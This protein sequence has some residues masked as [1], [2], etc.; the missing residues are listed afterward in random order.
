MANMS[1]HRKRWLSVEQAG[2]R[3]C[4]GIWATRNALRDGIIPFLPMGA[5]DNIFK[6]PVDA[7]G[8]LLA[9][10][11]ECWPVEYRPV[12]TLDQLERLKAIHITDLIVQLGWRRSTVYD[13]VKAWR[14]PRF[15]INRRY[16]IPEDVVQRMH[17]Y[18]FRHSMELLQQRLLVDNASET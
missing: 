4:L 12:Y 15:Q 14:I 6:I 10:A 18:A 2:E 17:D 13:Q 16:C 3:L 5:H 9:R 1:E 8:R 7:P 11:Y